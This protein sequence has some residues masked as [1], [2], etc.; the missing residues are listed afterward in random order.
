MSALKADRNCNEEKIIKIHP[1]DAKDAYSITVLFCFKID[2]LSNSLKILI[3]SFLVFVFF[4]IYGYLQ[5]L[6]F[7]LE[8]FKP[9]GLYLTFMQFLLYAFISFLEWRVNKSCHRSMVPIKTYALLA[10][11]TVG[12]IGLSN[13]SVGYL[14]YPTQVVF[15]CCKL[16]P[17]LIGGIIIQ[18]KI[19]GFLDFIAAFLMSIGIT[20]FTL[21]DIQVYPSF[22]LTGV[23]LISLALV[24]DAI[25]GNVQEK[26]LKQYHTSN[27][28]MVLYSYSIGCIYIFL[29][30]I[31]IGQLG[32]AT[33][34]CMK[35][36]IETFGYGALFSLVGYC[37]IQVVLD[38]IKT[39]GA[40][41][42]VII[43]TCRKAVTIILSFLLFSKPFRF[44]YI[45]SGI[46]ITVGIYLSS[47]SKHKS[48]ISSLLEIKNIIKNKLFFRKSC[49]FESV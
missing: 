48:S 41:V 42:A 35:Y 27:N 30:L 46:I 43:T 28:E 44:Q 22:N 34:V 38:L 1:V 20:L 40:F 39:C 13:T 14:N 25:I 47:Y 37:G 10:L 7:Q 29:I 3:C 32:P 23:V 9:F 5:E 2:H 33:K 6:I 8:E 4:I 36:P 49:T 17:V 31:A 19:Y 15:K 26:V 11:L 24:A 12:S 21:T 18:G 16:I 45:W